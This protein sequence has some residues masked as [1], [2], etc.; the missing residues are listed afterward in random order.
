MH[1]VS[2]PYAQRI[3]GKIFGVKDLMRCDVLRDFWGFQPD[4]NL[5]YAED[6]VDN[7]G[8]I[9][10]KKDAPDFGVACDGDA[11]RNMILSKSFIV[12]PSDSAAN[13]VQTIN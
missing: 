12:T 4:Q 11:D 8:V 7:M 13:I 10:Y 1:G 9:N 5:T 3:F 6:F 2:G